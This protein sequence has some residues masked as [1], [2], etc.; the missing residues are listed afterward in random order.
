[1][2]RT[3]N[4]FTMSSL[5]NLIGKRF[6]RLTVM[7]RAPN[8]T[9]SAAR[10][11]CKCDCGATTEVRQDHLRRGKT[12]SCACFRA[13]SNGMHLSPEYKAWHNI[14]DRCCSRG[15]KS[16]PRYGGRGITV[17]KR[18]RRS[19]N[20]F[21]ADVG[22]RP[23]S[24]Y[25]IERV[26]NNGPYSPNNCIWASRSD[27]QNNRHNNRR[28]TFQRKTLT[29]AQW[30]RQYGLIFQTLSER[31]KRGWPVQQ[32]LTQSTQGRHQKFIRG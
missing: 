32:A 30:A 3:Y 11:L 13:R 7:R 20:A 16:Y 5:V 14:I 1:M 27:Q 2:S 24:A 9:H 23:S 12:K 31:L 29:I 18:W 19:F 21:F 17:C 10:W 22:A 25:T 4:S 15:C 8:A 28:V 26:D 6:G